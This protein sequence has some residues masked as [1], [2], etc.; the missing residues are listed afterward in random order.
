M[1]AAST[2]H[3]L[4]CEFRGHLARQEQLCDRL[5]RLADSLP[6]ALNVQEGLYVAQSLL[7]TVTL[8][9]RFEEEKVFP[10]LHGTTHSATLERLGYEHMGDEEYAGDIIHALRAYVME[11]RSSNAEALA[12]MMRGFFEALRRHIAF[13]REHIL[14]LLE[15]EKLP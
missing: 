15:K 6:D 4:A 13:E 14:P 2:P 3:L 12:W 9:H 10:L 1:N 11:R 8:A 7:P 5:E